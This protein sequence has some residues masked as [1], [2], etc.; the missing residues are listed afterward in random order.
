MNNKLIVSIIVIVVIVLGAVWYFMSMQPA[1]QPETTNEVVVILNEQNG[2]GMSGTATLTQMEEGLKV[3]L[4]L[5]GAPEN[6]S[7]PAHIHLNNC[8]NIGGVKH[9]LTFPLN[10]KS[11]TLV[12]TTLQEILNNLPLSV[13]IHKS[14]SEASV[15]VSCGDIIKP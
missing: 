7:Q 5:N 1:A 12:D 2:S 13:N 8:A 9:P 4:G 11:E 10:G 3:V 15:Y 14:T 6:V